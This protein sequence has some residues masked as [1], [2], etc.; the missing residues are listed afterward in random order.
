M[1]AH[2]AKQTCIIALVKEIL[3]T[4]GG[5]GKL[6]LNNMHPLSPLKP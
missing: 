4:Y 1:Q 5:L 3:S 6:V 2:W